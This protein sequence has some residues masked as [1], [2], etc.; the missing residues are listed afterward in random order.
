MTRS[1]ASRRARNSASLTIGARR[2]PAS[3]PSRRRCFLASSRVEPCRL[4]ISS[5]ALRG[6][7]TR[8]TVFSGSSGPPSPSSP[9]R[10]RRRRRRELA[11]P[12]LPEPSSSLPSAVLLG[13]AAGLCW[14][15]LAALSRTCRRTWS[16]TCRRT[17]RTCCRPT[18]CRRSGC[19]RAVA[20]LVVDSAAGSRRVASESALSRRRPSPP[21]PPLRRRRRPPRR[22]R[23][24]L[25]L[26][27][28]SSA[29]VVVRCRPRV[30]LDPASRH[31]LRS[32]TV[33]CGRGWSLA[34]RPCAAAFLRAGA[35]LGSGGLEEQRRGRAAEA[36]RSLPRRTR[37][38]RRSPRS[39]V[40]SWRS[41]SRPSWRWPSSPSSR[42]SSSRPPSWRSPLGRAVTGRAR[43]GTAGGSAVGSSSARLR[44]FLAVFLA[45]AFLVVFLAAVFTG[46]RRRRRSR[47]CVAAGVG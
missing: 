2:R 7:R 44:A 19:H 40:A 1:T 9:A 24:R 27:R 21:P 23:R 32:S 35:V 18:C 26:A 22:R 5:S 17:C 12:S 46:A 25:L 10:R 41:S 4:V 42:W 37:C 16:R 14:P 34:S 31:R 13:L 39:S 6:L 15:C 33:V 3:R 38:R 29:V 11:S 45:A 20:L 47:R 28:P 30:V 36:P 43:R 8:V